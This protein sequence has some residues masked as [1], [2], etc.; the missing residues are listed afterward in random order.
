[1]RLRPTLIFT[2]Y[3]S[4]VGAGM[5]ALAMGMQ[6]TQAVAA[7]NSASSLDDEIQLS[8][9]ARLEARTI[10]TDP[11]LPLRVQLEGEAFAGQVVQI[12]Q[13]GMIIHEQ[14]L[15]EGVFRITTTPPFW[16]KARP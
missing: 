7:I 9:L 6:A 15:R 2:P 11:N 13:R 8:V 3:L 1:M 5:V 4:A 14:Q 16:T 12:E 10:Q